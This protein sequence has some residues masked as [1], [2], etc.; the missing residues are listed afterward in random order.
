MSDFT[1]WI[2]QEKLG[3]EPVFL[4]K[5]IIM[6]A[7]LVIFGFGIALYM[8]AKMGT[9]PYD[10]LGDI[11]DERTHGKIPY[12]YARIILDVTCVLVGVAFGLTRGKMVFGICTIVLACGTGLIAGFFRKLLT[13]GNKEK[14]G[15]N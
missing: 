12:R 2:V 7:F 3:F 15:E 9:A 1:V 10:T 4:L 8:E 14:N 5:L 13:A 11:I 6:L